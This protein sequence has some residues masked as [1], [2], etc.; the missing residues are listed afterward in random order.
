MDRIV[1]LSHQVP[2]EYGL[3]VV[4]RAGALV[5]RVEPEP[6]VVV[7]ERPPQV[8]GEGG[9]DLGAL[10][11]HGLQVVEAGQGGLQRDELPLLPQSAAQGQGDLEK[12]YERK[13][14]YCAT[15]VATV[16]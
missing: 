8:G 13:L 5:Q 4:L 14:P 7:A 1:E 16:G 2:P 12:L 15:L 6:A 9:V 3:V 11:Q 10:P